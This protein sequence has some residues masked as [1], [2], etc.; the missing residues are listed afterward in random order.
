MNYFHKIICIACLHQK[1]LPLG[2]ILNFSKEFLSIKLDILKWFPQQMEYRDDF[3][4]QCRFYND[5]NYMIPKFTTEYK[6]DIL[7]KSRFYNDKN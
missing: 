2:K 3:W 6:D 1:N 7:I 5:K 4:I